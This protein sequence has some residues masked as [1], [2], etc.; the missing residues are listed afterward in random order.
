VPHRFE[1]L[2]FGAWVAFAKGGTW[3]DNGS[4]PPRAELPLLTQEAAALIVADV[5]QAL[6]ARG[7]LTW[8]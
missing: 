6:N 3:R 1:I 8:R 2:S 4:L 5:E 7:A